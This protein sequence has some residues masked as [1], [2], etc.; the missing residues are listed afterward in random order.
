MKTLVAAINVSET[1]EAI[2]IKT[3]EAIV[4]TYKPSDIESKT[5]LKVSLMPADLQKL[6]STQDLTDVVEYL[7]TLKK[8]K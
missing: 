1:K 3:A 7:T 2:S 5:Q 4:E 6:M 8:A